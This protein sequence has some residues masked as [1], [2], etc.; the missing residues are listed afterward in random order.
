MQLQSIKPSSGSVGK[1]RRTRESKVKH[2]II[3]SEG[4]RYAGDQID[5]QEFYNRT[6]QRSHTGKNYIIIS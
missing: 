1:S 4:N 3:T 6:K 2:I 5:T